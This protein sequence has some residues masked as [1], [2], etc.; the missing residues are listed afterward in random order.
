MKKIYNAH[1]FT[2]VPGVVR[3]VDM[4]S[5]FDGPSIFKPKEMSNLDEVENYLAKV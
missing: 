4:S 3:Y 1:G 2:L 5:K